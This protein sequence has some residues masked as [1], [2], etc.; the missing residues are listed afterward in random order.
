MSTAEILNQFE[1]FSEDEKQRINQ[2]AAQNVE[3]LT[4]EDLEL[5]S[6]WQVNK[7]LM[8]ERFELEREQ[9]IA[10]AETK[11]ENA[12]AIRDEAVDLMKT[13][14]EIALAKLRAI[15]SVE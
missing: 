8:N 2:L 3:D 13:R 7:A 5:Y 12:K 15:E 14:K 1:S 10:I 4:Q 6:R 11:I 9:Q